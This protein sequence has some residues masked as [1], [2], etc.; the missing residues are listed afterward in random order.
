[1]PVAIAEAFAPA[2]AANLGVG[3]DIIGLALEEPGDTIRVEMT[4]DPGV[5]IEAIEGDGNV[6]PLNPKLNCASVAGQSVLNL[7]GTDKGVRMTIR[8]GLPIG[9]GL[10]SSAASSVAGAFAVNLLFGEPL[11]RE[12]LLAPSLDGEAVVSGYHPDN[13]G[14]AL[15]G[16]ITL[17]TGPSVDQMTRLPVPDNLHLALVT[18]DVVVKTA[19]A[20]AVLPEKVTMKEMI[21]QTAGTA[22]LVDAL[23]RGDIH[24]LGRAMESDRVIEPARAYLMPYFH[25]IRE[26][27]KQAG[28]HGLVISGAGPTLL[29]VCDDA[30]TAENVATVMRDIYAEKDI[31]S[32][33]R[34]GQVCGD[35]ARVL[36]TEPQL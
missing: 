14:P 31:K 18:P 32:A 30:Q 3:F 4:D 35:G 1:M 21:N 26:K 9:S 23:Y 11:T 15:F 34:Y 8:K 13:V 2:T 17:F 29:A 27:A 22:L 16:G 20:R 7:I 36:R 19:E 28:A 33:S 5:V 25:T 10:G 24:A 12:Q 6:L